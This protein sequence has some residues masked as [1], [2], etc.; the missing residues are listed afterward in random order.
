MESVL[1][2]TEVAGSDRPWF[3]GYLSIRIR[4]ALLALACLAPVW[5]V[6][7]FFIYHSYEDKRALVE[8]HMV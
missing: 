8:R 7:G 2:R 1:N 6:S 4:L 5:L 3:V